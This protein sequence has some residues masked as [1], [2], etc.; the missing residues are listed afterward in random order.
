MQIEMSET[1]EKKRPAGL[2]N[3]W[4]KL[5]LN[6]HSYFHASVF[7]RDISSILALFLLFTKI[8]RLLCERMQIEISKMN[9]WSGQHSD[10]FQG[11]LSKKAVS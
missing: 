3:N 5:F 2:C 6:Q 7:S 1:K 10:L 4:V 9:V 11:K 8:Y